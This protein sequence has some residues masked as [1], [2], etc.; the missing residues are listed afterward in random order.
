MF[1]PNQPMN[2]Y[3]HPEALV[4]TQWL[5]EHLHDNNLQIVEVD[6]TPESYQ[7]AHIPGAIFWNIFTDLLNPDLS[8]NL[9]TNA[10][11]ALLSRSGITPETTVIAYGSYPGTGAW[12]LW[13]LKLFG[14]DNVRVLNGGH[15]KWIAEGH[16]VAAD[17]ATVEPVP[18]EIK[19]ETIQSAPDLRISYEEI[20]AN[21]GQP[22]Q[23]LLDVRTD[24]EYKGEQ[25]LMQPPQGTERA[26]H[27]PGAVHV[28]HLLSLNKDGT[29]K[30]FDELTAL[31]T[32][33]GIT[34]D[35][36][37]IP[38]CAIG[39]RAGYV[40]FVLKYLLGYPNVRN[41]DGSWNEWS[42]QP[43]ASVEA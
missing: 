8:Q 1:H 33:H 28:E 31:Y 20:Q 37:V 27:I 6:M 11:E 13:L 34:A 35:K 7:S 41:Y 24:Q 21:F 14:H 22:G 17:F 18:Y 30:S 39:A 9:E 32:R 43:D 40:W 29:F 3:A 19:Q 42:R 15:Q 5:A 2:N 26:G 38:Y 4:S 23:V 36:T 16:P 12:I 10:I 25:F